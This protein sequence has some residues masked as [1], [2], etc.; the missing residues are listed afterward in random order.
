MDDHTMVTLSEFT[1]L[2]G[3]SIVMLYECVMDLRRDVDRLR[4][5]IDWLKQRAREEE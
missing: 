2:T 5:D 4:R 1:Q 3:E